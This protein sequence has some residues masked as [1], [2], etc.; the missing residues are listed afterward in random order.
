MNSYEITFENGSKVT[1]ASVDATI[2]AMRFRREKIVR[3]VH[4]T[5][6]P[7][8][9]RRKTIVLFEPTCEN[10][11]MITFDQGERVLR[12]YGVSCI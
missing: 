3:I 7:F 1:S 4:F 10:A 2:G 8:S 9:Y 5:R 12:V 11:G 6:D